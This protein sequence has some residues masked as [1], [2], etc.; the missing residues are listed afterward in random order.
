MTTLAH[1]MNPDNCT[2]L[3]RAKKS[4]RYY[5]KKTDQGKGI[6]PSLHG[7]TRKPS[8][9]RTGRKFLASSHR[10]TEPE[11]PPS[12]TL[13]TQLGIPAQLAATNTVRYKYASKLK[14]F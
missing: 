8:P 5:M 12:E 11:V 14:P 10:T 7:Q 2:D 3:I 6:R 4:F 13:W 1:I 9:D